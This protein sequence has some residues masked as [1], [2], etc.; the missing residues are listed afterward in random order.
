[1]L[2]AHGVAMSYRAG[3]WPLSGHAGTP[4]AGVG[5]T[6]ERRGRGSVRETQRI[7]KLVAI[8]LGAPHRDAG[9]I[10]HSGLIGFWAQEPM[11]YERLTRDEHFELFGPAYRMSDPDI[12]RSTDGIDTTLDFAERHAAQVEGLPRSTRTKLKLGLTLLSDLQLLLVDEPY[13]VFDC[14]HQRFWQPTHDRRQSGRSLLIISHFIT[15]AER[16]D[17]IYDLVDGRTIQR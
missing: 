15:D 16:F 12:D 1:M 4:S 10:T 3:W 8:L 17:R 13:A 11:S 2:S 7:H 14:T 9:T 6:A 5:A